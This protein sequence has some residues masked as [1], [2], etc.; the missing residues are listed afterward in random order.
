MAPIL[1]HTLN[2][3]RRREPN[4]RTMA[5]A[6]V[7]SSGRL[8]CF[9]SRFASVFTVFAEGSARGACPRGAARS[10]SQSVISRSRPARPRRVATNCRRRTFRDHGARRAIRITPSHAIAN[11]IFVM[12]VHIAMRT[13][14][15][16]TIDVRLHVTHDLTN[17]PTVCG[18]NWYRRGRCCTERHTYTTTQD[19][20]VGDR[21]GSAQAKSITTRPSVQLAPA[22]VRVRF[23]RDDGA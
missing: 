20:L 19:T 22:R 17:D 23:R 7:N 18:S 11:L 14:T 2:E 3:R 4:W 9:R 12:H 16:G 5:C 21:S 6:R 13:G 15:H 10:V 1:S 8:Q